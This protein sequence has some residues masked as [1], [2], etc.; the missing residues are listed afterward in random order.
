MKEE[1]SMFRS[2][3]ASSL[4]NLRPVRR[5]CRGPRSLGLRPGVE[6]LEGREL[7]TIKGMI[8]ASIS[9]SRRGFPTTKEHAVFNATPSHL[10]RRRP[11]ALWEGLEWLEPRELKTV[12]LVP[13]PGGGLLSIVGTLAN[14]VVEVR[15]DSGGS[16]GSVL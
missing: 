8:A 16:S 12:S 3:K 11:R 14:D 2:L 15:S 4:G 13:G 10:R 9:T 1:V 5:G 7:K 6:G